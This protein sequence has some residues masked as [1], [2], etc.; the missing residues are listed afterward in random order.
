MDGSFNVVDA[1]HRKNRRPQPPEPNALDNVQQSYHPCDVDED[2]PPN[3]GTPQDNNDP[4]PEASN[5][6]ASN[7]D[8]HTSASE[9][10]DIGTKEYNRKRAKRAKRHSKGTKK[11]KYTQLHTYPGQW[12]TVLEDGKHRI[13]AVVALKKGFMNRLDG[14]A[15]AE[16]CL[17]EAMAAHESDGGSVERGWCLVLFLVTKAE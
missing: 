12:R 8:E 7:S 14:L 3:G 2:A 1:H 11:S 10:E 6:E 17:A 4:A 5:S 16:D 9:S 15:E 13:R